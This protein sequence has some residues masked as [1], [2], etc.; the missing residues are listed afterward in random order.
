[1]IYFG[2]MY[3]FKFYFG[4][5]KFIGKFMME[6]CLNGMVLSLDRMNGGLLII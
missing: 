4:R 3:F 5:I 1:M 2:I 6:Y